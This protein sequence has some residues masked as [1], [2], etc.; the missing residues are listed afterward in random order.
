MRQKHTR[1]ILIAITLITLITGCSGSGGRRGQTLPSLTTQEQKSADQLLAKAA[2]SPFPENAALIIRASAALMNA[3][4]AGARSILEALDYDALPIRLQEAL[5][6]Q[7]ALIAEKSGQNWEIFE[8]LDREAIINSPDTTTSVLAHTLRAR[9]YNR[10]AEYQA[11]LDEWL[12]ALPLLNK[13]QQAYY[14]E[15]FWKTLLHVPSARLNNLISQTPDATIKGWLELASLYQPGVPLEQQ[16]TGM[17]QWISRRPGHPGNRYIPKNFDQLKLSSTLRPEKI[18]VLL[19][20]TGSLAK[21]GIAIRDGLLAASYEEQREQEKTPDIIFL[22]TADQDINTLAEQAIQQGAQLI[23]GPLDK[24]RV[25]QIRSDIAARVPILALNYLEADEFPDSRTNTGLFQ[26]GLSNEDEARLIAARAQLDGHRRALVLIPNSSWGQKIAQAFQQ[27]WQRLGGEVASQARYE[28]NTEFSRLMGQLLHVDQSRERGRRISRLLKQS[29]ASQARRRQDIDMVFIAAS[30]EE[31][32]QI[33]PALSYQF[34][35]NLPVYAAS[36]VFSGR[37]STT[38]DQDINGI[39][40]PIMPWFIPGTF[41]LGQEI[42]RVWPQAR[43][44]YGPLYA[45]GADAYR[46]YPRLQQLSSLPGSQIKGMTGWLSI[47]AQRRIR[48]E[49]TWQIFQDGQLVPLPVKPP[50]KNTDDALAAY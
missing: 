46:L 15:D 10:F 13:Q 40:V 5:A 1:C 4:P 20:L 18:A 28:K 9:A 34:A 38:R 29:V 30:P 8:W 23:I 12:S 19:P 44:L 50:T 49:L 21:A 27:E 11:A 48:R 33:K 35:S 32:R 25:S 2:A 16:L 31:A 36:T 17:Q 26:F 24:N 3:N 47:D 14:Q 6:L 39:R 41:E 43:G 42:T 45:L 7:Q 37:T 22:D